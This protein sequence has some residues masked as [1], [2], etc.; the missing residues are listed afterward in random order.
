MRA[1]TPQSFRVI[2]LITVNN[3]VMICGFVML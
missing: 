3:L 1:R 2:N